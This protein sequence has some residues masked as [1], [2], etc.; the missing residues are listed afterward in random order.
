MILWIC[1][2]YIRLV[3]GCAIFKFY[4]MKKLKLDGIYKHYKGTKVRVL[5]TALHSE[6]LEEMVVYIHLEDG[7][8]WVRPK[9]MFL[10]KVEKN[11]KVIDRF[12][13]LNPK[14][15]IKPAKKS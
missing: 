10:E 4:N 13:P 7:V 11:G 2:H 9:K 14:V 1:I 3:V 12:K 5:G 6:T 15:L 8:M